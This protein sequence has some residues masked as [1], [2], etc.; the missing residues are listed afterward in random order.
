M[1][2]LPRP[3][4]RPQRR[5]VSIEAAHDTLS[6]RDRLPIAVPAPLWPPPGR[7][8]DRTSHD[9]SRADLI[10]SWKATPSRAGTSRRY[11]W[12]AM[13]ARFATRTQRS[14]PRRAQSRGVT[15]DRASQAGILT[16]T[17]QRDPVALRR[18]PARGRC[19]RRAGAP[20]RL[21]HAEPY[22]GVPSP[23]WRTF[24]TRHATDIWARL[25][26]GA[27]GVLQEMYVF[28]VMHHETR[29]ILQVRVTRHPTADWT[30]QQALSSR[31]PCVA[32]SGTRP[33]SLALFPPRSAATVFLRAGPTPAG[34]T[35]RG[36]SERARRSAM[37]GS[38]SAAT[39][40]R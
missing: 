20:P 33:L 30:P 38:S 37:A 16:G 24:L 36:R 10:T 11:R 3:P 14:T 8:S 31:P 26:R 6:V 4:S 2:D 5:A 18:S 21:L 19:A 12:P 39:G 27:D 1:G 17:S 29:Q 7:R 35:R 22:D 13:R 28:F 25:L 32:G 9:G 34:W 15:S 40:S 23:T